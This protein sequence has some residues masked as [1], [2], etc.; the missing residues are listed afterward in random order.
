MESDLHPISSHHFTLKFADDTNL[1][2]L[3][4]TDLSMTDEMTNI[5]DWALCNKMVIIFSKTKEIVFHRS[6]PGK[7][8]VLP[9]F[10]YIEM[11]QQAKLLGVFL[12]GNF[13]FENY[14]KIF[15]VLAVNVF[16]Y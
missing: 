7:F 2:V 1:L 5:L 4:H 8:S 10:D 6:H 12:S 15:Y 14:V 11:A 16:I 9:T 3:E 13:S